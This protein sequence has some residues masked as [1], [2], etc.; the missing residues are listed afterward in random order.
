MIFI[1]NFFYECVFFFLPSLSILSS[2]AEL[3]RA[4][5]FLFCYVSKVMASGW[6]LW[7]LL[8]VFCL[9]LVL[10]MTRDIVHDLVESWGREEN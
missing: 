9:D 3:C 8:N 4:L 7:T 10:F 2:S 5:K 6:M 1:E